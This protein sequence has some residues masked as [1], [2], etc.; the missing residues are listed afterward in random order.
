VALADLDADFGLIQETKICSK[1]RPEDLAL[2]GYRLHRRDRTANGGGV[3]VVVSDLLQSRVVVR[4]ANSE[5]I[6]VAIESPVKAILLAVYRPP[7]QG[8]AESSEWLEELGSIIASLPP[9]TPTLL[10]GDVNWDL[11]KTESEDLRFLLE[12]L[13]LTIVSRPDLPTHGSRALDWVCLRGNPAL[14]SPLQQHPPLERSSTG[15]SLQAFSLTLATEAGPPKSLKPLR[16]WHRWD[17][18]R[19]RYESIF[20]CS[21]GHHFPRP[22]EDR[23]S[24]A[25]PP[26]LQC[27]ALIS[28]LATIA[29]RTVPSAPPPKASKKQPPWMNSGLRRLIQ[30]HKDAFRVFRQ[31]GVPGSLRHANRLKA[32]KRHAIA[33]AKREW[34]IDVITNARQDSRPWEIYKQL[35]GRTGREIPPLTA[36]G[37]EV[38]DDRDKAEILAAAFASNFSDPSVTKSILLTE[39]DDI[40]S[41]RRHSSSSVAKSILPTEEEFAPPPPP[42][43]SA[44]LSSV[45]AYEHM[46]RLKVRKASGGDEIPSRMLREMAWELGPVVANLVNSTLVTRRV[47]AQWRKALVVPV[48]KCPSPTAPGDFRPIS[49]LDQ[50]SKVWERHLQSLLQPFCATGDLQFAFKAR[51]SCGD[52]LLE[53]QRRML[54]LAE[55]KGAVKISLV[56]LDLKKAFDRVPIEGILQVLRSRGAPDFLTQTLASWLHGREYSVKVGEARSAWRSA[57]SGIP[58]GSRLGPLLFAAA[59][60]SV[61]ELDLPQGIH[62]QLFADDI[63]IAGSRGT[64]LAADDFQAALLKVAAHI[65]SLGMELNVAKTQLLNISLRPAA[66]AP[67]YLGGKE[68]VPASTLKYLGVLLDTRLNFSAHW[69]RAAAS[70]KGV[71]G[72]VARLCHR[73]AFALRALYTERVQSALLYSLPFTPPTT[74]AAWAKANGVASFCAHLISNVWHRDGAR[75]S[76]WD[77]MEEQSVEAVSSLYL[78]HS[79][80]FTRKSLRGRTAFKMELEA[81]DPLRR[82]GLRSQSQEQSQDCPNLRVPP[83]SR[84]A[85]AR[86]QPRRMALLWNSA[87]P[88]PSE[89]HPGAARDLIQR[90]SLQDRHLLLGL[91]NAFPSL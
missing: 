59:F 15:H 75:V 67:L 10:G 43:D 73:D 36:D 7:S 60:D 37:V 24:P 9:D 3:A 56:S 58:Q 47:P 41:P 86:L 89:L 33:A 49:L 74:L 83:S 57:P 26:S 8:A 32:K 68:I 45:Q 25:L 48:P 31:S 17:S 23:V 72:A 13:D 35:T 79:L 2:P 44:L 40:S 76:G 27:D 5:I 34:V 87:K 19:A 71:L 82:L 55:E 51:T 4:G 42:P 52:A 20:D 22:M 91:P 88:T 78:R 77:L 70:A 6:G 85:F 90:L 65:D 50:L 11:S 12:G 62:L 64:L 1:S 69:S 30:E 54:G 39:G 53:L 38:F 28:E 84:Q 81:P 61:L 63:I 21:S 46:R 14:L 66:F 18:E 29:D 80:R 16:Q